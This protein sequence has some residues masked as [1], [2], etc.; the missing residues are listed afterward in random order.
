[1]STATTQYANPRL[2]EHFTHYTLHFNLPVQTDTPDL[3][4]A[5]QKAQDRAALALAA[6]AQA[7]EDAQL[8]EADM[9]V[10]FETLDD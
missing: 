6:R 5:F 2:A 1:M 7:D 3:L 8:A 9:A 10:G 4:G